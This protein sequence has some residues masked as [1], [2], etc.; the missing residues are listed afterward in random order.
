MRIS[1]WSSDVCSSDLVNLLANA[2]AFTP[3]GGRVTVDCDRDIISG[4]MTLAVTDTG[5]GM[6]AA[7]A[8]EA[9]VP[10]VSRDSQTARSGRG[11]GLEIGRAASRARVWQD[12]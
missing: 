4:D 10:Y 8:R 5:P 2:I 7:E 6:S 9:L 1:D 12:G 3:P 11:T